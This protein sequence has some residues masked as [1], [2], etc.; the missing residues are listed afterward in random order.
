[1]IIAFNGSHFSVMM[2][3]Y[4]NMLFR[5]LF[6]TCYQKI[7]IKEVTVSL[8]FLYRGGKGEGGGVR[9]S[10]SETAPTET[11]LYSIQYLRRRNPG[12]GITWP[13]GSE[14]ATVPG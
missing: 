8:E 3:T 1:M 10:V 4:G 11:G 14:C 13:C 6:V 9:C 12:V 5:Q 2:P 7:Y